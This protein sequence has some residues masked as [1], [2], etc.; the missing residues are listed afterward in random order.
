MFF[1]QVMQFSFKFRKSQAISMEKLMFQPI[2][3]TEISIEFLA[4]VFCITGQRMSLRCQMR[5]NL[6][7]T[8]RD[9]SYFQ[10][11]CMLIIADR[12]VLCFDW[13]GIFFFCR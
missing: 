1:G 7:C 5:T 13:L 4:A 9:Q 12:C 8:A 2:M 3:I 6:M 10:K 11:S